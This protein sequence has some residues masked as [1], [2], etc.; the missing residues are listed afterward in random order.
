MA[1]ARRTPKKAAKKRRATKKTASRKKTTAKAKAA[2]KPVTP[3]KRHADRVAELAVTGPWQ[4][5]DVGWAEG[6]YARRFGAVEDRDLKTWMVQGDRLP[7]GL[8]YL[9]VP[10]CSWARY[11]QDL[12][13]GTPTVLEPAGDIKARAHQ[14]PAIEWIGHAYGQVWPGIFIGDTM[15]L[16]K[17]FSAILSTLA[18]PSV[19]PA[20]IR[21]VLVACP[22]PMLPQWQLAWRLCGTIGLDGA[23][24]RV[25][26]I[27]HD[28]LGRLMDAP[29]KAARAKKA[30]TRRRII[31]REGTPAAEF[32][33][34]IA[35]ES[36]KFK[37]QDS[38]RTHAMLKLRDRSRFFMPMTGTAASGPLDLHYAA[39]I[40]AARAGARL[41]GPDDLI[42]FWRSEGIAVRSGDY[43]RLEWDPDAEGGLDAQLARVSQL[44][45]GGPKAI[46]FRRNTRDVGWPEPQRD[47]L[48]FALSSDERAAY[49]TEWE[50][51][52]AQLARIRAGVEAGGIA[53]RDAVLEKNQA[54]IRFL[55]KASLLR[56]PHLAEWLVESLE[57]EQDA[58]MVVSLL[59]H[60]TVEAVEEALQDAGVDV[61]TFYGKNTGAENEQ[62]RL[63]FQQGRARVILFSVV[64][65]VSFHAGDTTVGGTDNPR[66]GVVG[67]PR[68]SAFQSTQIEGRWNRDG[69]AGPVY[70]AYAAGTEEENVIRRL[71]GRVA[72]MATIHGDDED[73]FFAALDL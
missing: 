39:P 22:A 11:T 16:G 50:S 40:M 51:F 44:L 17:T 41:E 27:S 7:R 67:D 1:A 31:T 56:A 21:S 47:L 12:I 66:I 37:G 13:N 36:H 3:I 72:Q 61:V 35:D 59:F 68:W 6:G 46:G 5:L 2:A 32:D 18:M 58:V 65:G 49:E 10:E 26:V 53:R 38:Q 64:E 30:A 45:F 24:K 71:F 9:G 15:G 4:L 8:E 42:E 25:V 60:A 48:P 43:G 29:A 73:E 54:K 14:V 28:S 55:Q 63:A 20:G 62:N 70:Y 52:T 23:P 57:A 19:G 69:Q 33:L 34:L